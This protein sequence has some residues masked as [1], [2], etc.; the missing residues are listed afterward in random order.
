MFLSF[1]SAILLIVCFVGGLASTMVG[2]S[3]GFTFAAMASVLP[4]SVVVPVHATVEAA[5]SIV[6]CALLRHYVQ[7]RFFLTF[8]M[9][10]SVGVL[11]AIPL[12]GMI[13]E[14]IL[15]LALGLFIL[16]VTWIPL[17][18]ALSR[19]SGAA[20]RLGGFVTSFLTV[21]VGATGPLVAALLSR[22]FDDHPEV[23]ATHAACMSAQ[24]AAK[25]VVFVSIGWTLTNFTN[26]IVGMILATSLGT[27]IGRHIIVSAPKA[28]MAFA[29]KA[30]VSLLGVHIA[31]MAMVELM[32]NPTIASSHQAQ[33]L[34][35]GR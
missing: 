33:S 26:Q 17:A 9:F 28:T 22:R 2:T 15:R 27:W 35:R 16:I 7:W 12:I 18:G 1:E 4:V 30:V 25:I 34:A 3:G 14:T 20:D 21:F 31:G 24:H 19:I 8:V 10:G 13:P 23:I 6:R 29:L 5:A 32:S 11:I